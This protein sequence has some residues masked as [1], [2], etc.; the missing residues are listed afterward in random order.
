MKGIG[1]ELFW[2]GQKSMRGEVRRDNSCR[3]P[4]LLC[5][6]TVTVTHILLLHVGREWL[7]TLANFCSYK[8]L[9]SL[10]RLEL[11]L[12]PRPEAEYPPCFLILILYYT[13]SLPHPTPPEHE[14]NPAGKG[15]WDI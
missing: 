5:G 3:A 8:L 14:Q 11:E 2:K 13:H 9:L 10:P 4:A 7:E 1:F 15:F 12:L 6:I